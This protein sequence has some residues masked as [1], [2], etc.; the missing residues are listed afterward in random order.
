MRDFTHLHLHTE[1][2]L[3][4]SIIKVPA[5]IKK[6]QQCNMKAMAIT[7]HGTMA[8]AFRFY[9]GCN[10]AG[11]KPILGIECYQAITSRT[12]KD[13][14]FHLI[15]LAMN[16][17]GYENLLKLMYLSNTEG[18]YRKPRV[19]KDLL[20]AYNKGLICSS[21]CLSGEL[22]RKILAHERFAYEGEEK[23]S[24]LSGDYETTVDW[25]NSTFED[26]FYLELQFNGIPAQDLVNKKLVEI[27]EAKNIPL[28]VTNDCHYL[29]KE[30]S[31]THELAFCIRDKKTIKDENRYRFSGSG[32][33]VRTQD[34]MW[35]ILP[36]GQAYRD[37]YDRTNE[38][39]ERCNV[40]VES[41]GFLFPDSIGV[42]DP[43]KTLS[44]TCAENLV[45][46]RQAGTIPDK[47]YKEKDYPARLK[48]ELDLI[49]KMGYAPYFLVMADIVNWAKR[50]GIECGPGRGSAAGSLVSYALGI[51]DVNPIKH[52]L[53]FE[54]FLNP[55]RG[56]SIPFGTVLEN[57]PK[58]KEEIPLENLLTQL[59]LEQK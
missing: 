30:D 56:G 41:S 8:G 35:D 37:A 14:Y 55:A 46:L 34:E 54:R 52:E 47:E 23:F 40:K 15:L 16:Q 22:P 7:D 2:S 4:D 27:G 25:F 12:E 33:W 59:E 48:K 20:K 18:F 45:K 36:E 17:E 51:T 42:E 28:I 11:I 57:L 53:Y 24:N 26:R 49:I 44:D 38:V 50:N 43:I 31:K 1:Y 13:G 29:N 32:Y 6:A 19:D 5:L 39:A 9:E 3:L 21:A 58:L 10:K